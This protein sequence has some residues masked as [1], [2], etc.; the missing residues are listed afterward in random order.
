MVVIALLVVAVFVV[1][2]RRARARERKDEPP[3]DL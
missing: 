2:E 1:L 3:A